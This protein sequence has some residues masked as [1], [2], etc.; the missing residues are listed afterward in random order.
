MNNVID[1]DGAVKH[2]SEETQEQEIDLY[3]GIFFDG[4]NNNKYQTMLGKKFRRDEILKKIA[5]KIKEENYNDSN[6]EQLKKLKEGGL[7]KIENKGNFDKNQWKKIKKEGVQINKNEVVIIEINLNKQKPRSWWE[8]SGWLTKSDYDNLYFGYGDMKISDSPSDNSTNDST[9]NTDDYFIEKHIASTLDKTTLRYEEI[10]KNQN[11][12]LKKVVDKANNGGYDKNQLEELENKNI[13]EKKNILENKNILEK[14]IKLLGLHYELPKFR[15]YYFVVDSNEDVTKRIPREWWKSNK[16]LDYS[17]IE[18]LYFGDSSI[19]YKMEQQGKVL[20]SVASK[21]EENALL[22]SVAN[23]FDNQ[24]KENDIDNLY[25]AKGRNSQE[26]TYTNVAI[27]ESLYNTYSIIRN[28]K[29]EH[30]YSIYVEGSG[31]DT[32]LFPKIHKS[33]N[34]LNEIENEIE[35]LGLGVGTTG[36]MAKTRIVSEMIEKLVY[37]FSVGIKKEVNLHFD[38]FGFSRGATTA[39]AFN[40]AINSADDESKAADFEMITGV[41]QSYLKKSNNTHLKSIEVRFMGIYDTVSSIGVFHNK[42]GEILNKHKDK[43]F[44]SE[45]RNFEYTKFNKSLFH[46]DNVNNFGLYATDKVTQVVHICALDEVRQNFAL[47]DIQSSI[48]KEKGKEIF[49]PGCHTDIGGG[50]SIGRETAKIT[51][52]TSINGVRNYICKN[53]STSLDKIELLPVSSDSLVE[54][55]W[56]SPEQMVKGTSSFGKRPSKEVL[57]KTEDTV[58]VD[59]SKTNYIRNI[60]ENIIM[61]RYVKPGYSNIGLNLM[62]EEA[63]DASKKDAFPLFKG[64]PPSYH[65]PSDLQNYYTAVKDKTKEQGRIIINPDIDSYYYLRNN[66]L[67]FS[68]NDQLCSFADNFLVNPPYYVPVKN[69]INL[70]F[71]CK[72]NNDDII[73]DFIKAEP[74]FHEKFDGLIDIFY[75]KFDG[76]IDIFHEKFDGLID[77]FHEKFDGL[78]DIF[79]EKNN[80]TCNNFMNRFSARIIY[81]G[82]DSDNPN[83]ISNPKFMFDYNDD[84]VSISCPDLLENSKKQLKDVFVSVCDRLICVKGELERMDDELKCID[85]E[86]KCI[87]AKFKDEWENRYNKRSRLIHP[88]HVQDS[89]VMTGMILTR[90]KEVKE[91]NEKREKLNEKRGELSKEKNELNEIKSKLNELREKKGWN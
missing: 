56:L 88:F 35:G 58:F 76:L 47:V 89:I 15:Q 29:L 52:L 87:D 32:I 61:Y 40:Y 11:E 3:I 82:V 48:D 91:L 70:D 39:R 38:L 80:E 43:I 27:L 57:S 19:N 51:N 46:E 65:V 78:I 71:D 18:K 81:S 31:A 66:Y 64:I 54:L 72:I 84:G 45:E 28:N 75:E 7:I 2:N 49:L 1:A 36:V 63:L 68:Y 10:L 69:K 77:I 5:E 25:E 17:D 73:R 14:K 90:N 42:F 55:G 67:H 85:D 33:R 50:A 21:E 37:A 6:N 59:N 22:E 20:S 4:T 26:V 30:H 24:K 83:I 86:L 23:S 8:N 79:H 12:I 62:R 16:L 44:K 74:D 13:L 60:R 9:A 34:I 41:N 53:H